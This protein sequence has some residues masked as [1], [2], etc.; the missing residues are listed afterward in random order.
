MVKRSRRWQGANPVVLPASRQPAAEPYGQERPRLLHVLAADHLEQ[1]ASI[2]PVALPAGLAAEQ[3]D[4]RHARARFLH[5][6]DVGALLRGVLAEELVEEKQALRVQE[7]GDP[8]QG[9]CGSHGLNI[10]SKRRTR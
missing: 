1:R 10:P 3:G 6:F 7:R 2:G 4:E 9:A 8:P 5:P